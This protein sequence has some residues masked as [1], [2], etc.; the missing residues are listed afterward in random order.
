MMIGNTLDPGINN[1]LIGVA[2]VI[3]LAALAFAVYTLVKTEEHE[4][5]KKP[6][7]KIR[8]Q[9]DVPATSALQNKPANMFKD[10]SIMGGGDALARSVIPSLGE[11]LPA[12]AAVRLPTRVSYY[13]NTRTAVAATANITQTKDVNASVVLTENITSS[14][15]LKYP[16]MKE[17]ILPDISLPLVK[18]EKTTK[19][20]SEDTVKDNGAGTRPRLTYN[21]INGI[22]DGIEY[23]PDKMGDGII[24]FINMLIFPVNFLAKFINHKIK[25]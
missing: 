1:I 17:S 7:V 6:K 10:S 5:N 11:E 3:V 22:A 8:V 25:R 15:K 4:H 23:A 9:K 18:S 20:I 14:E 12:V 21:A 2:V 16:V 19:T 13:V 24:L